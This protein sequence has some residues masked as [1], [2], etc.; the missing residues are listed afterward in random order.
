MILAIKRNCA[1]QRSPIR[2]STASVGEVLLVSAARGD[3]ILR[4][5]EVIDVQLGCA[6]AGR[7]VDT[8]ELHG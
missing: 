3:V 5:Q 6:A 2:S 8:V 7:I 1:P 4:T